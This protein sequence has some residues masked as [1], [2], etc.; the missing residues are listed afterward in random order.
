[1]VSR[2]V[3][4]HMSQDVFFLC[5]GSMYAFLCTIPQPPMLLYLGYVIS[6][7][8]TST[9]VVTFLFADRPCVA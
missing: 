8:L 5:F 7:L 9:P 2:T 4:F 3:A 1:M 6:D